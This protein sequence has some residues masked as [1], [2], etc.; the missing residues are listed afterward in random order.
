MNVLSKNFN[1]RALYFENQ[2][3]K[4]NDRA[5]YFENQMANYWAA[6]IKQV[7]D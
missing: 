4:L 7:K 1:D 3:A 5:L 2:M 6:Q